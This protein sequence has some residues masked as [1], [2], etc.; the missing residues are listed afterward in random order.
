MARLLNFK[1]I[2]TSVGRC[3]LPRN[4]ASGTPFMRGNRWFSIV[5]AV[6]PDDV[7]RIPV[8]LGFLRVIPTDQM[9]ALSRKLDAEALTGQFSRWMASKRWADVKQLFEF[10]IR[11]L[12][13]SGNPNVPDVNLYNFYLQANL[14]VGASP[15]ELIDLVER[16]D[17]YGISPNTASFNLV[18]KAMQQAGETKA[19]ETLIERMILI[20]KKYKEALPD[21]E[22]Y[23]LIVCALLSNNQIDSA[24]KYIDL[25]LKS[26]YMLS[27]NAFI[28]SLQS[29][30]NNGRLDTLVSIIERC[31][32]LTS[33]ALFN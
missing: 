14:M 10:W 2:C 23:D 31:K 29:C 16:M 8:S 30:V 11:A 5:S 19:A 26:G 20:G 27:M 1:S 12:D 22:S 13:A 3:N 6:A 24:V 7:A 17:Y 33:G 9:R 15:A 32:V 28:V 18:L 25:T 4:P 21:Y